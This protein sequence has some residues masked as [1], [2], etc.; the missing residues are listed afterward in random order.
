M[1]KAPTLSLSADAGPSIHWT[2]AY[3][4]PMTDFRKSVAA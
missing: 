1:R 4:Q 3:R 2:A